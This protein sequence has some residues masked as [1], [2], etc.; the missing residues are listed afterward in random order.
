MTDSSFW[1]RLAEFPPGMDLELLRQEF[2]VAG[3]GHRLATVGHRQ[4]LWVEDP[5]RLAEATTL[6]NQFLATR[7][8]SQIRR[9][10]GQMPGPGGG[11]Y[12]Q[13]KRTPVLF[14]C[15][16]LSTLGAVL[17][18]WQFELA[19]Y[20][21][22]QDFQLVG[23]HAVQFD[24]AWEN[25]DQGQYWRLITPIFIHFGI[26]HLAFNGLWLWVFGRPI[27][28]VYGSRHLLMLILMIGVSSNLC[29]YLWEGPSLFG[30]LSG[31]LYGLLGYRWVRY[32]LA[33]T[34]AMMLPPGI[35]GFMLIWL[36][37]C[38]TGLVDLLMQGNIANAAHAS[39]LVT[40]LAIGG[41]FGHTGSHRS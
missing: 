21:T 33:P 10:P 28:L 29:Q 1:Q 35:V 36:V 12:R 7:P 25:F 11:F 3:I 5:A 32:K 15:L 17:V 9:L 13:L 8:G 6:I 22:F 16:F 39:G 24:T 40:G 19:H 30:G 26:F 37:I 27:E 14:I 2:I 41:L 34:P 31:V 20:F 18:N 23:S 38:M 4:V